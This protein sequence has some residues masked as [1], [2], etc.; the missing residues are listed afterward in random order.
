MSPDEEWNSIVMELPWYWKEFMK[1]CIN[2]T[3]D[4]QEKQVNDVKEDTFIITNGK[5]E[6][7]KWSLLK[8]WPRSLEASDPCSAE[9]KTENVLRHDNLMNE[10]LFVL[11]KYFNNPLHQEQN[12]NFILLIYLSMYWYIHIYISE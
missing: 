6:V 7:K 8:I 12:L 9:T 2:V 10:R 4:E 3:T 1:Y 11:G 5:S